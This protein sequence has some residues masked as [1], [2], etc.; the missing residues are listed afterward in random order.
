MP[1][2]GYKTL[3][4]EDEKFCFAILEIP[5]DALTNEDR[6]DVKVKGKA[7]FRC[8]KATVVDIHDLDGNP[9]VEAYSQHDKKF[10]Y[11]MEKTSAQNFIL[12]YLLP[13]S[14]KPSF[15]R[16]FKNIYTRSWLFGFRFPCF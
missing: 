12:F 4:T 13:S 8:S 9:I 11:T 7:K 16:K 15:K 2:I 10:K 3:L 5:D 14:F 1:H 6:T